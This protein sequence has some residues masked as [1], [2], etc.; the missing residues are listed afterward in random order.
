MDYGPRNSGVVAAGY[1]GEER[2]SWNAV[3][4]GD[5]ATASGPIPIEQFTRHDDFGTLKVSPD[6]QF[7]ALT[8]GKFGREILAF[9]DLKDKK[10]SGGVRAPER[11]E[12]DDFYW[13][14]PTRLIY[15]I[16]ERQRG[17][18]QPTPT[19]EIFGVDRDGKKNQLLYGYRAGDE[20]SSASIGKGSTW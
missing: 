19:G 3:A 2:S 4:M 9:I 13:V 11:F 20:T 17:H 15:M 5:T 6:G 16:A 1:E 14:S 12:I 7:I 8:T 10:V 18:V